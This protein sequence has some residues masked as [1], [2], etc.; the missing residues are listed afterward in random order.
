[1]LDFKGK[2]VLVVVAHPD[3]ESIG[4]GGSISRFIREQCEVRVLLP[5]VGRQEIRDNRWARRIEQFHHACVVLGCEPLIPEQGLDEFDAAL[6]LQKLHDVIL[7]YV[8]WADLILCHCQNDIHQSH[9]AVSRAVELAT[10]PFRRKKNVM[11]FEV[12]SSSDQ[13][14]IQD[15]KQNL[16]VLLDPTDVEKKMQAMAVYD[17]QFAPGRHP[18]DLLIHL[19]R[20]GVE[21]ASNAAECFR[22]GRSFY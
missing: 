21:V 19:R 20:R 14:Y 3:D 10:R 8:E 1:M 12:P 5:L 18:D 17:D 13:G 6:N 15:F 11:M 2:K 7:P 4:C 22:I 16:Y 9:V